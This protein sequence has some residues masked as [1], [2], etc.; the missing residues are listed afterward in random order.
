MAEAVGRDPFHE[1]RLPDRR[2]EGFLS[3][4]LVQMIPPVLPPN[5]NQRQRLGRKE[6]LP[7]QF[8]WRGRIFLFYTSRGEELR[9]CKKLKA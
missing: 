6:P 7:D 5:W 2:P 1:P 4:R 9:F 3:V 8:L